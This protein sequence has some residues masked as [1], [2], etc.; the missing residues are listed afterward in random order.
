MT[1]NHAPTL[2]VQIRVRSLPALRALVRGHALD[3]VV[4]A[5]QKGLGITAD[6]LVTDQQ[7]EQLRERG[8]ELVVVARVNGAADLKREVSQGN[9]FAKRLA[10]ARRRSAR[11]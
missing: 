5:A 9:R 11:R 3:L 2:H 8:L 1:E 7:A 4:Y 6:L 10:A